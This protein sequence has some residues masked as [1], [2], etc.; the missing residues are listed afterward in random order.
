MRYTAVMV[1]LNYNDKKVTERLT[2]TVMEYEC[3]DRVVV[4]DNCS[5]DG[6]YEELRDLFKKAEV[7]IIKAPVNGGYASGNNFGIRYAI[8]HYDPEYIFVANPDIAVNETVIRN[9]IRDMSNHHTYGVMAP[10]VNQGYNVW[11]LPDFI[12]MIES[13]FLVWFTLD[14]KRI[15]KRLLASEHS[16]VDAGVVEG[17]FF[18]IRSKDFVAIDGFDERTFLYAEEIILARRL[19]E[20][21]RKIGVLTKERYDHLHSA[22]IRKEYNSSK[23]KAFPNFYKSFYIYNKYYLHTNR[24]QDMIFYICYCLAYCERFVYDVINRTLRIKMYDKA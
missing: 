6:S 8:E 18:V 23:R 3:I 22:S 16:I 17:S 9:M 14:K 15:R 2:R 20:I 7:D 19:E 5:P 21:G 11:K 4:V 24:I 10:L 1:I 13:L 12:G